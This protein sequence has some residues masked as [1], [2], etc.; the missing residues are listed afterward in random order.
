MKHSLEG[1]P[2]ELVGH[3]V[4]L[5]D[6]RDILSLRLTSRTLSSK[7]SQ[8][9]LAR[10]FAYKHVEL[11]RGPLVNMADMT[12]QGRPGRLL[13]HCT[14]IGVAGNDM[15][16]T[17]N[18]DEDVRLLT[19]AFMNLKQHSPSARLAS[20]R[21]SVIVRSQHSDDGTLEPNAGP[22]RRDI[23]AI[24]LRTFDVAITALQKSQ[25]PVDEH[26]DM[27]GGILGCS[28]A[29]NTL[30]SLNRRFA[31]TPIFSSLKKLTVS[32]SSPCIDQKERTPDAAVIIPDRSSQM[33][34]GTLLLQG[35]L[36]MLGLMPGLEGLDIHW[37]N[38]GIEESTTDAGPTI[39][40]NES[41][42]SI[43]ACLETCNLRG[44]YVNE[45]DLLRFIK[46][47]H[48][49]ALIITDVCL[50]LGTWTSIFQY[51]TS[52]GSPVTYYHLDDV[53]EGHNLVHFDVPGESKFPYL[54]V[55]MGPSTLTR[56]INEV[57][58]MI[59]FGMTSR[60]PLGS[61]QRMRWRN[62]KILEFGPSKD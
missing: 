38:I 53:R 47:V 16:N 48:P 30:L 27:F 29:F 56:R 57:K 1:L 40:L 18:F 54:G 52:S 44:L 59:R 58:D 19:K 3:I 46:A 33:M 10:F 61:G 51:L 22:S 49:E 2:V 36:E 41:R 28:L 39:H 34:H 24:A 60:R 21:L 17:P 11:A 13:Q 6:C 23:W 15:S 42:H 12:S 31:S 55:T 35:L 37:Y 45:S 62:S 32:L 9:F 5:L 43:L 8:N 14:I 50:V 26:L 25:L 4:T 7:L 20:L